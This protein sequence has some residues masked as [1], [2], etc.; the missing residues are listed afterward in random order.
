MV[1]ASGQRDAKHASVMHA[2]I[3]LA[4]ADS[5]T[6]KLRKDYTGSLWATL[7]DAQTTWDAYREHLAGHPAW[8]GLLPCFTLS[9]SFLT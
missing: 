4:K 1:D 6:D 5:L 7:N 2:A 3:E 9:G 8:H